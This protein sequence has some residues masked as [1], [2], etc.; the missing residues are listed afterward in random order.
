MLHDDN[1][2]AEW[3]LLEI[4][5]IMELLE[6]YLIITYFQVE[7]KFFQQRDGIAVGG[8]LLPIVSSIFMEY[9]EKLAFDTAQYK[10]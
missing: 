5:A 2:S 8:S 6:V 7:D 4:K 10:P 1:T 9:F 3:S